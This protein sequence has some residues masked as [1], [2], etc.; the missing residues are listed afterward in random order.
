MKAKT[1]FL[2]SLDAM[3]SANDYLLQVILD[4]KVR[5]TFSDAGDKSVKQNNL[6]WMWCT[7]VSKSG[8]G[9]EHEDYEAGVHLMGKYLFVHPILQK[10]SKKNKDYADLYALYFDK[11]QFDKKKMEYFFE[12]HVS[13]TQLDKSQMAEALT[14]FKN[15]YGIKHGVNLR[16]PEFRG[17]LDN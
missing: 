6:W 8:I 14:S 17:L 12:H 13:T 15:Y 4:G 3:R 7:D 10:D 16:E 1:F 11:Y 5:V 2:T 9:G